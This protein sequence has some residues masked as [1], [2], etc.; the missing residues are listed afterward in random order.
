MR[1]LCSPRRD[2]E[3]LCGNVKETF[4]ASTTVLE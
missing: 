2:R 3:Q 4:I 1:Q